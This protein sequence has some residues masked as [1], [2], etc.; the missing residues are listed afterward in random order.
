MRG[1]LLA[2]LQRL[3]LL[4]VLLS[5][6]LRLLL[7]LLLERLLFRF[8]GR[9][10]REALMILLL[11]CLE[12][13]ALFNLLCLELVLLLL[14][15]LIRLSIACVGSGR[16][17]G[18][19]NILGVDCGARAIRVGGRTRIIFRCGRGAVN[20]ATFFGGY[21]AAFFEGAGL[22]CGSDG[23]LAVIGRSA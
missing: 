21:C 12:C 2:L 1:W 22:S 20:Y 10:L 14:V 7:M 6:L 18:W 4:R 23:R 8:I 13:L 11:F 19:L 15:F 17:F 5:K 3:L 9:L 16:A